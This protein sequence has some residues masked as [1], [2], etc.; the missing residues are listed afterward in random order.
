MAPVNE[1]DADPASQDVAALA[2]AAAR[3]AGLADPTKDPWDAALGDDHGPGVD[4]VT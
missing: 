4:R 2:V 3:D 1:T